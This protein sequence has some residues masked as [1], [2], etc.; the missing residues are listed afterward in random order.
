MDNSKKIFVSVTL[1][2]ETLPVGTLWC[3]NRKG[4][5]SASFEYDKKWLINPKRF[6]LEPALHLTGCT[7]YTDKS[8]FGSIGDSAPDRWGRVLMRRANSSGRTLTEA[9]YLLGVDDEV[10]QGALRFSD[11]Y[12]GPYLARSKE[13]SIPPLIKL[14][15]L[16]SAAEKFMNDS[17]S[18]ADLKLLLAPGSSLGGA[19]PKASVIDNDG[20]L[21]IA[22][23]PRK[24]DETDIIRWEAV[25][26]TLAQM[27]GI[28]VP[29][30]RL[31]KMLGKY[32]L[33]I[34]RFDRVESNRIPFLSA[35]AML[36]AADND[37]IP[38]SY[39]EIANAL[40]RYGARPQNDLEELWRRMVFEIMIN[41]TDNHLRNHGFLY[42]NR[43]WALSPAYDLNPNAEKSVFSTSIDGTGENNTIEA[44]MKAAV[45]FRLSDKHAKEILEQVKN[46][47][48]NWRKAAKSFKLS[49]RAVDRMKTAFRV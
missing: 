19:R 31:E 43:E 26:L 2:S 23:F 48:T 8:L 20:E 27:A 41:N 35:M 46:A 12:G 39:T 4:R 49:E 38:H 29:K 30:W 10:R 25:A 21:A 9:D 42:V 40:L 22:K 16:L 32:V 5:K 15:Q 33:I 44:A 45:D 3:Y 13:K 6:A 36:N 34:K 28:S 24:N 7:H 47:V 11:N 17:E 37:G 1:G 18:A 14:P